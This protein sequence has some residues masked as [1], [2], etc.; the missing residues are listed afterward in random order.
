MA[1]QVKSDIIQQVHEAGIFA[2]IADETQDISR[3]EQDA[4][5]LRSDERDLAIHESFIGFYRT[6]RIGSESLAL[7][8]KNVLT[9]FDL[10]ICNLRAQCYDGA[11]SMRGTYRGV[12]THW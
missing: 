5:V 8:S 4:V 9:S 12:L 1:G 10:D 3:H 6:D 11:T 2:F 7:L